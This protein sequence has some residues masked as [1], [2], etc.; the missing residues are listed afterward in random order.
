VTDVCPCGLP[1]R[2]WDWPGWH[3]A[4]WWAHLWAFPDLNDKPTAA[5]LLHFAHTE[6]QS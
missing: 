5:N 1:V 2:Y 3:R 6:G 4:H